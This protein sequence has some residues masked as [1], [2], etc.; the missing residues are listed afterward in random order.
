[1]YPPTVALSLKCF[2]C[3]SSSLEECEKNETRIKCEDL[4][5]PKLDACGTLQ[6]VIPNPQ[7]AGN[8]SSLTKSCYPNKL[9]C[10][11]FNTSGLLRGCSISIC[12]HD[13][14]N[15]VADTT[16]APIT[17]L[18]DTTT[19]QSGTEPSTMDRVSSGSAAISYKTFQL[20]FAGVLVILRS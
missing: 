19:D 1:M 2:K 7:G 11:G 15:G 12:P 6:L 5:N 17:T 3:A 18:N 8:V 14:C 16:L 13:Y 9:N 20:L 4:G 10:Q